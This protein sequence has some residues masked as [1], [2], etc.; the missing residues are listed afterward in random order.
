MSKLSKIG[1]KLHGKTSR[2]T[3][4]AK[5]FQNQFQVCDN[6]LEFE[7]LKGDREG[8]GKQP[9]VDT[10]LRLSHNLWDLKHR[11]M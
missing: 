9:W 1:K 7:F 6:T 4:E 8:S 11:L 3:L 5:T 2:D 10:G